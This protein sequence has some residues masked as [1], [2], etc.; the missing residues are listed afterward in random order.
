MRESESR[1]KEERKGLFAQ[2]GRAF[3]YA[4]K[5]MRERPS[6]LRLYMVLRA[7]VILVAVRCA[8]V[9]RWEQF[10]LCMLVLVLFIV[11]SI[12]EHRLK[13]EIPTLLETIILLFIFAAEILGE[14][15]NFYQVFP[16]WDTVLHTLNG[17]LAA[18]VGFALVDILNK[19]PNV[20]FS[21]SPVYCTFMAICFAM[22]VGTVWEMFEFTMDRLF[23]YDMQKDV[24][25]HSFASVTLGG[26]GTRPLIV[27]GITSSTI[28]WVDYGLGGYLDIGL[29]DT[30]QDMIVN[31][32]GALV[33]SIFGYR[34]LASH[35]EDE[36]AASL[37]PAVDEEMLALEAEEAEAAE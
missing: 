26:D 16:W 32:I 24:V 35:G 23:S 5:R 27:N 7:I 6:V 20:R 4:E 30:M 12:L 8:W 29:F 21:L 11:P 36:L 2:M 22:T 3:A 18:A 25:V 13:M 17:F 31:A 28:N 34:Y 15:G 14:I 1:E 19:A 10:M 33:F 9:G 37:I